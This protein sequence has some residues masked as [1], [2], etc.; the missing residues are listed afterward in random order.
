MNLALPGKAREAVQHSG[1]GM[2]VSSGSR[3]ISREWLLSKTWPSI[4][5]PASLVAVKSGN[6]SLEVIRIV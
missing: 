6:N 1:K 4:Q 3:N 5:I 2:G